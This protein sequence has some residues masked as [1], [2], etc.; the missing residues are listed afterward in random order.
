[1]GTRVAEVIAKDGSNQKIA[2]HV[3][4]IGIR[5]GVE[6]END[7]VERLRDVDVQYKVSS[8]VSEPTYDSFRRLEDTSIRHE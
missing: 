1:M 8:I 4:V 6:I 2:P 3:A 7:I 5:D